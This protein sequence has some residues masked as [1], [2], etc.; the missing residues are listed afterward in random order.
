MTAVIPDIPTVFATV[1][2]RIE[3]EVPH[4]VYAY[5]AP[6]EVDPTRPWVVVQ[7]PPGGGPNGTPIQRNREW[8]IPLRVIGAARTPNKQGEP[9]PAVYDAARDAAHTTRQ[10]LLD[11]TTW[12]TCAV[13]TI[14]PNGSFGD[15]HEADVVNITDDYLIYAD[16]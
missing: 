14:T 11:P 12:H 9:T 7:L 15:D 10:V 4:P 13:V 6:A 1:F 5:G 2:A 8:L 3:T 16:T